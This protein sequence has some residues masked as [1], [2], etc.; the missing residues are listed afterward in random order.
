[1][2]RVGR[3]TQIGILK[4]MGMGR[5]DRTIRLRS[6]KSA[7]EEEI[8]YVIRRKNIMNWPKR[9]IRIRKRR[10]TPRMWYNKIDK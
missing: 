7:I 8:L 4:K 9:R 3:K 6:N 5:E 1:M 10:L 2:Q